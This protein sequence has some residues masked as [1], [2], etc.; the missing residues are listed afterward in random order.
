MQF[1]T[2]EDIE[3]PADFVFKQVTDFAS[4]ERS[5]IRRGGDI[6]RIAQ[7]EANGLGAK[8]RVKF[9]L[10]GVERDVVATVTEAVEPA[11]LKMTMTS[12]SADAELMVELVPLSRARTRLNVRAETS[13]KTI[14]A[15]LLFQSVRFAKQ[16]TDARFKS[17]VAGFANDVELRSR[18]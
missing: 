13:A 18:A 5:I 10:R 14:A 1:K 2:R 11:T 8:W 7:G 3:A 17:V 6:E 15:K 4:F 9:Q 12:R 16:K